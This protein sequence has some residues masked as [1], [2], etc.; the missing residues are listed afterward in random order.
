LLYD[1]QSVATRCSQALSKKTAH[2][3]ARSMP[4][5]ESIKRN[6]VMASIKQVLAPVLVALLGM[7]QAHAQDLDPT[8]LKLMGVYGPHSQFAGPYVGAKFGIDRSDRTGNNPR[9]AHSTWY[10][11]VLGGV[12]YDVSRFVVGFEG[13]GD[14]H[15]GATTYKDGGVDLKVGMPISG[16]IMPYGR[17]GFTGSWPSTRLHYGAGVEYKF[18]RNWSVA[19]E[20][21]G[22]TTSHGGSRYSNNSVTV[23]VHYY[24]F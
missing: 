7:T 20:Y 23:G 5:G 24:F 11:G 13:F 12:N 18:A 6:R 16:N 10:P 9:S 1:K 8:V 14:F 3:F 15:S 22:D 2:L 17:V 4:G 19:G 21:T